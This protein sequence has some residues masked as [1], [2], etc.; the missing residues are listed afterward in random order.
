ME[1]QIA[2]HSG[3]EYNR[4]IWNGPIKNKEKIEEFLLCGGMVNIDSKQEADI[5]FSIAKRHLDKKLHVGVR[6]NFDVNDGV[7][8][9][10]GID[11]EGNDFD[12]VLS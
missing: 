8:S 7:M 12:Y 9:R 10:F 11:V 5:I 2:I 6:C 1:E 3:V 4:I